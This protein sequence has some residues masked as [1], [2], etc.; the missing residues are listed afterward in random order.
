MIPLPEEVEVVTGEE[1][2]TVL[3]C[4][5]SKLYRFDK[6]NKE[7]IERG[8]GEIKILSHNESGKIR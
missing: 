8:I 1:N 5:N 7:W 6:T 3:F 4:R 2:E